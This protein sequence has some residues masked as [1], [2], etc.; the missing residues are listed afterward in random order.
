MAQQ[1]IDIGVQGNDGTG[2]SIRTSFNKVNQN[3]TE[4]YAIFG[5]GGTI[6][7]YNLGDWNGPQYTSNQVIMATSTGGLIAGRSLI[8]GTGIQLNY[9]DTTLTIKNT[10]QG[11]IGDSAPTLGLPLNAAQ[12]IIGNL[13]DPSQSLVDAF[14]T[15]YGTN[16]DLSSLAISK[17]YADS[18]YIA[19][20]NGTIVGP[21]NVRSE[22][23]VPQIG[24][25]GYDSTLTGNYLSTE[26]VQRKDV[27]YRGGDTMA[28]TLTLSDHPSPLNGYGTP[29]GKDDLQAATKFYVDNNTYYSGVN[30]YVSATKGDDLQTNTPPGREGRA[31]QYAYKTVGAAALAADNFINLSNTEP[32]PYRQT[33]SYTVGP[34]QYKSTIQSVNLSGGNSSIQ[35]YVDAAALLAANKQFIQYETVAYLNKKYVNAFD[36]DQTVWSNI[37]EGIITAVGDDLVLSSVD[38]SSLTTY[39]VTAQA[40]QLFSSYNSTI[41]TNQLTQIIDGIDYARDQILNFSYST[42]N[43]ETYISSLIDA[44]SYDL[45]F[46]NNYQ[47]IQAALAFSSAN[48]GVEIAEMVSLLDTTAITITNIVNPAGTVTIS[49]DAQTTAPYAVNSYIII[50]GVT[51]SGYNGIYKVTACTTT[52]V[53]FV[54]AFSVSWVSGGTVV[55]RNV[56]NTLLNASANIIV[57]GNPVP[58]IIKTISSAASLLTTNAKLIT[59]LL[60]SGNIPAPTFPNLANNTTG[61]ISATDLLLANIQFIQAELTGFLTANY[62]SLSYNRALS[63]RDIEYVVWSIVYDVLYGGNSQSVYAGN[64]YRYNGS[65]HL[66]SDEQIACSAA[67][68]YINTLAQNIITNT[69]QP[70]LYQQTVAQYTNETYTNGGDVGSIISSL[71]GNVQHIV[72]GTILNP[73]VTSPTVTNGPIVLQDCRTAIELINSS[74]QLLA[75]SYINASYP[76]INNIVID[77]KNSGIIAKLF[78]VITDLLTNGIASRTTPTYNLPVGLTAGFTDAVTSLRNN[79]AFIAAESLARMKI[80]AG[81]NGYISSTTADAK[82]IKDIG[83]LVEAVIYDLTYQ[84]NTNS[85]SASVAA[86]QLYWYGG[87]LQIPGQ[88]AMGEAYYY[89]ISQAADVCNSV[90]QGT[91]VTP[92][93]GNT[94]TQ[95]GIGVGIDGSSASASIGVLFN[96][97]LSIVSTNASTTI[98]SVPLVN[99]DTGLQSTRNIIDNN[100]LSITASTIKYLLKKY[101]GGFSYNESTCLRDLGYIVDAVE[102]DLLTGGNYQSI[103]AGKSYYRNSI[104][105]SIA[106]GTQYTETVDGITFARDLALQVLNQTTANRFQTQYTQTFDQT[107]NAAA[108]GGVAIATF[109]YNY[110]LILSIITSGYGSIPVV[111]YGTGIYT[112]TIN[113]GSQGHVDQGGNITPGSQ[114]AIHIIPGKVLVGNVSGALGQIVSYTSAHDNNGSNDV[115]TLRMTQPGFF[116]VGETLDFG[117]TVNNLNITIY[118]ESGTY[119]EDYPIKLPANCTIAGDDFRRTIIRP[120]DRVSQSPW[121]NTFFYRDSVIDGIQTG[122][123]NFNTDYAISAA[124]TATISGISGSITISLGNNVQALQSW[125]G[126]V[127]MDSTAETG[128][129]GKAVINTVSG[130]TMN[131]TV[132]YPFNASLL[133]TGFANGAWHLYGTI[134]YG[135]HYLTNPLL[136]EYSTE[137]VFTGYIS[138]TTLYINNL[139]SGSITVGQYVTNVNSTDTEITIG[140]YIINGSGSTWTVNYGQTV[141][142]NNNPISMNILNSAKNNKEL[143]VFLVNDATRVRLITCQGHGGFMMVLDPTG[144]IKTKSPYAQESASF[145]GS[146]GLAKR[147]AGGQF[148]DGFTGRL[149]GVVTEIDNSG[150]TITVTGGVNS[151]LDLRQPQVPCAFYVAGI[152]Y[153]INDVVSWTQN[154]DGGGNITGGTVVLTLDNSTPFNLAGVYNSATS[155]FTNNLAYIVDAVNY[156]MVIGSNYKTSV[157]GLKYLQ[158]DNTLGS[159]GKLLVTQG[160]GQAE[161]LINGLGLVGT[162]SQ[163]S[164]DAN[165]NVVVSI[166]NNGVSALPTLVFPGITGTSNN[167][168]AANNLQNNR[169]FIQAEISAWISANYN[170]QTITNYSSVVVQRDFGYIVDAITYDLLYGGNS[171]SYD[172]ALS[173]YGV[174]GSYLSRPDVYVAAFARLT[175]ILQA[176]VVNTPVTPSAGNQV[177]QIT[178]LPTATSTEQTTINTLVSFLIDYVADGVDNPPTTTRTNPT[179]TS[180]TEYTN[181]DWDKINN[182]ISTIQTTTVNY[183]NSGAG[184]VINIEMGGNKS[185]LAND[186]TQVNDLGYGILCTNAGLTEQV[187]TFTYYCHTG[188]WALNGA[189]IR[190]VAGSNANGDYGLRATGYDV[191]ELPDSV[192]LAYNMTQSA[193]VYKQG[194]FITEMT[195]TATKQALQVYII[196]WE[197][198]P[199]NTSELEIDHTAAGGAVVRYEISTVSHT[200]VTINGTNVLELQ[201]STQGNN[202]TSTTGLNYA[203]YDGQVVTIRVLQ[204]IKFLN[205]D[206]VKPVRPS[207]ALQYT[208]NLSDIYRIIA[209]N[210]TESTGEAL[211]AN[212]AL[213]NTD[214]S[215]NYYKL[216]TDVTNINQAD[217]SGAVT[218]T[219]STTNASSGTTL[220]IKTSTIV[221]PS[222]TSSIVAGMYV[223]GIGFN[224]QY[225]VGS[226]TTSGSDTVITLSAGPSLS[227]IGPVYFSTKTQGIS[228]SDSKIAI[229]PISSASQINQL[230]KGFFVFSWN[231]RT[232]RIVSYTAPNTI[233]QG[234]Y[235]PTSSGTTLKVTQASGTIVAG[236]IVTGNGFNGTQFVASSP[237]PTSTTIANVTSWTVTLTAA[238]SSTPGAGSTIT[239][240]A[241]T[242][243]YITID[244]NPV[245]NNGTTGTAVSAMSYVSSTFLTNSTVSKIITFNIPYNGS[246]GNITPQ[247]PPV[248]SF[249]NVTSNSNTNYNQSVQVVGIT[250]T[251]QITLDGITNTTKNLTVGMVISAPTSPGAQIPSSAIIQS[252]DSISQ[253]TASPACWIPAGTVINA[254]SVA[255]LSDITPNTSVGSGYTLG[256]PPTVV[257][258]DPD[259]TK[260]PVRSAIIQAT[261]NS[262]STI[263][264]TIVDQGYGYSVA[265]TISFSGGSGNVSTA[266]TAI[267]SNPNNQ[268]TTSLGGNITTNMQL[269]YPVDPGTSGSITSVASAGTYI[270][271]TTTTN[272]VVNSPIVFTTNSGGSAFGNIVSGTTYYILTVDSG[273]NRITISS[274]LQGTSFDPGTSSSGSMSFYSPSYGLYTNYTVTGTPIKSGTG[275]YTVQFTIGSNIYS[276][277]KYYHVTGNTN[278]LYNGFWPAS[279]GN[280]TT[281]TL[282]YPFDPGTWS[283]ATTTNIALETTQGTSNSLGISKPFSIVGSTTLRAGYPAGT[284]GQITVRISTCRATGHDFLDIGTGGFDTTNYPN[285]IYGNPT[286]PANSANQVLEET[287]G[288]V[289]HVSTDENGIFQVGRFFKVDQGTG[290]VTFAA[291]IALSNLD[292]LGFKRGVVVS[293]FSTD[294]LMTENAPDIVPVQSAVRGFVDLRLGLDYGGNPVPTNQIIG[295]GYLPL[296]GALP[297]KGN[298]NLG[299]NYIT[300]VNMPTGVNINAL[301]GVNRIYVDNS[302]AGT[303]SLFKLKDVNIGATALC[304]SLFGTQLTINSVFGTILAGQT[305]TSS[306]S[307]FTGQTV[308]SSSIDAPTG[309]T[310]VIISAGP[311]TSPPAGLTITFTNLSNGNSLVYDATSS[312]WKNIALPTGDVNITYSRVPG[313]G[314]SLTTA[315]QAGKIYDSMINSGAAI[316][317]SK[318]SMTLAGTLATS[319]TG[320]TAQI[321]AA[322]GL[323]S[324]DSKY[325][326]ATTAGWISL[327]SSNSGGTTG[328]TYSKIQYVSSGSILGN[329]T[330]NATTIQE[331]SPSTIVTSGDGI[332]NAS[333]ASSGAMTIAYDGSN[334]SN[335]S[336]SVTPITTARGGNSLLKTD[337]YGN[338]D[339]NSLKIGSNSILSLGG[340]NNT[341][342]NLTTPGGINFFT[343]IGTTSNQTVVTLTGTLNTTLGKLQ[344]TDISTSASDVTTTGNI[345]GNWKVQPSSYWDVTSGTLK[346]ATLYAGADSTA[347]GTMQGQWK[348]D[349]NTPKSQFDASAGTLKSNTLTTGANATPGTM[350][351]AWTLYGGLTL[352]TNTGITFGSTGTLDISSTTAVLK[353]RTLNTGA[354]G[355]TGTVQGQWTINSGSTFVATSIQNQTNSATITASSNALGSFPNDAINGRVVLRDAS[356]NF[357]AGTITATLSGTATNVSN[358]LTLGT[359]L[360]Y[361]SG[362]SYDGSA[363]KS[364]NTD[365]TSSNTAGTI[366]S[367][368]ASTSAISVGPINATSATISGTVSA[369]TLAA[370]NGGSGIVQGIWTLDTNAKFEATYAADLAE[371][372]EGDVDYEVGTVLVFGGDKEVTTTN[373]INDTRVAGV[374]SNNAAYIM[375]GACPG[376]KNLIAL[377]GRVPCRVVGRVKKGDMLTTSATPGYAVK[378]LNPTLGAIIGKALVDK[379]SGEAGI[380]EVAIGRA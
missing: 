33:I 193:Y 309:N 356:G 63:R 125:I 44:L 265:P 160:I 154:I 323:A 69:T 189:Q 97:I 269:L 252:I 38:G 92:S 224:G 377:Q 295:P 200:V 233:A 21:L 260:R 32:G 137:A 80:N 282:T 81:T 231:G 297:F 285:Q 230:N 132:I 378:A 113:N 19:T 112:I 259:P 222:G 158:P 49:F 26:A 277:G 267:L 195:P 343:A 119:Y 107:K 128:T 372:Y 96:T 24:V 281:I 162:G 367:R 214:S 170:T 179:I 4:I 369:Y 215:F 102:I 166:I 147:F 192:N 136:P 268:T 317:Q 284:A 371:Y 65:L 248:D 73:S 355:T 239:F 60:L 238:P 242:N 71:V 261:V 64:R 326:T 358:T 5:G 294:S 82:V 365:A 316:Q 363:S 121:R 375:N 109:T 349:N 142:D 72:D 110:N 178:T 304:V 17:G 232:H 240:G 368:D 91:G 161:T 227:A 135:R 75:V 187:S 183:L 197:Y 176:I 346:S 164:I 89:G 223:G 182:D 301:D 337:Q 280:S 347:S 117:E 67:I 325:F 126:L 129:A 229:I 153:Q 146:L 8:A 22:P 270:A 68:G 273:T 62:P 171:A 216:V 336:Y 35:E 308:V 175:T 312:T 148:I 41:V 348:L 289:F 74:T 221:Y 213:L 31:W 352:D 133:T 376:S 16:I 15:L 181:G 279:S 149:S 218:A 87:T 206:N 124:T 342:L 18:R 211:P 120:L 2:D 130:N 53:S 56:I 47:S 292:G 361:S 51:P 257:L 108:G 366:V 43:L 131:C 324:F 354:S 186:F 40:S 58:T 48:T 95:S 155:V 212:T 217:P 302:V 307:Y 29:D 296:N 172:V 59:D 93:A 12:H 70:K 54:S 42:T 287:V 258:T 299:N 300:N 298:L 209:Y 100:S 290:T 244:P 150:K 264:L 313:A 7:L 151:G 114:S 28:G 1:I 345:T 144:Q 328:I 90:A 184:I 159:L 235:D 362:S 253:F 373:V 57:D 274:T 205:I 379:D 314:G 105:K 247:L 86:A 341:T 306:D 340:T 228:V 50:D 191:T 99:F 188:Y 275:P 310:V 104:A 254:I 103:N 311:G 180:Y 111:S 199:F 360:S 266:V 272:L 291:S 351:G 101:T 210:L 338:I 52:S 207:T 271:V 163:A 13:A 319:P 177:Q 45:V 322:N 237:A 9:T 138:G 303:N 165:L 185:M 127:F 251:T 339:V 380:I 168:K 220:Y 10:S 234:T 241:A 116:T 305:V 357:S 364:I 236:M 370:G 85:N 25:T 79:I 288:R 145:S 256:S 283:S 122:L 34:T 118:L 250:D 204:N 76:V 39:N 249:L 37:I 94:Q 66:A 286:I 263:N 194:A 30:L 246:T 115:I 23:L 98:I 327:A 88:N 315:I 329:L 219:V 143:D 20:E 331:I 84:A 174:G 6:K 202:G 245:Y 208:N 334:T 36:I 77:D 353:T 141:G 14:N 321:Q 46:G 196:G 262:D 152:R 278:T 140:T 157:A 11:L 320:T 173:F 61:Q 106:I 332:K 55:A 333:F 318:L 167:Q 78:R 225:V 156:D 83:Y 359:H 226:P 243:A 169:S 255:T 139:I 203:L 198:K 374:V 350:T 335:N 27:V 330:G 190:S 344:A 276:A 293:E 123:I 201:L 3:F 134:N